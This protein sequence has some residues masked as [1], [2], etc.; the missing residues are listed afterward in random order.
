[1]L[2]LWSPEQTKTVASIFDL[3]IVSPVLNNILQNLS[4]LSYINL[5]EI[6]AITISILHGR[7]LRLRQAKHDTR[8][9]R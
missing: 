6:G 4:Y 1:M 9:T 3:L 2:C 5:E 7:K 8:F